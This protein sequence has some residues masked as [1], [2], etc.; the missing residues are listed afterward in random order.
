MVLAEILCTCGHRFS[1]ADDG[2]GSPHACPSCHVHNVLARKV[3]GASAVVEAAPALG[4]TAVRQTEVLGPVGLSASRVADYGLPGGTVLGPYRIVSRIGRGGM[5][6]VYEA[7]DDRLGSRVALKVLSPDLAV[8]ADFVKRF[9]REATAL[10][11]LSD[12]RIA[13]VYFSGAAEGLPFFAMEF[14][15]GR[16]LE[17][18]L[19]QEGAAQPPR[20]IEWMREAARGLHS[21]AMRGIIHRDVKPT[22]LLID[23]QGNLRIVDFGLAK[24]V[25]SESRLTMTGQVVGTPFYL[26][27]EQGLG[28]A[29]D[30]R[31]DIYSLGATFYHLLTG[32]PPFEAEGGAVSIIM[33]HI[34][35]APEPVSQRRAGVPGALARIVMR[36]LAKDPARRYQDY[37]SLIDDLDAAE[38]GKP[39]AAPAEEVSI[40]RSQPSFVVVDELDDGSRLLRRASL[41]RRSLA[42]VVDLGLLKLL[43]TG[44]HA[45]LP[46][47]FEPQFF[48]LPLSF[49]YLA[50]G[51][52]AGGST[53]GKRF[54][55]L[56]VARPDG[57]E[58]GPGRSIARAVLLAP[59]WTLVFWFRPEGVYTPDRLAES[60][61]VLISDLFGYAAPLSAI[62]LAIKAAVAL[63]L[64]DAICVLFTRKSL[65][66]HDL[67]SG[68]S[69]FR[70][71]PVP[72]RKR[73]RRK[74]RHRPVAPIVPVLF[75][76]VPGGGQLINGQMGKALLMFIGI[77]VGAAAFPL[78]GLAMYGL[79]ALEAY[80]YAV[81]RRAEWDDSRN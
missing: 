23:R 1:V 40:R 69:V 66:L 36:C 7:V 29:V 62:D 5:G 16:N 70:E 42:L 11:G 26:S 13:K 61:Q 45:F 4:E 34:N 37:E 30:Q 54:F 32:K 33:R 76:W 50:I 22:N 44:L 74:P 81:D 59:I 47:G 27:P 24:A 64:M 25:D 9:H 51:D 39:V 73:Q 17:E 6:S 15:D 52:A 68:T 10:A 60:L 28:K 63:V 48:F 75:A 38:Q 43:H 41:F 80:R 49:L 19:L 71:D 72:R 14:I 12:S 31:S 67:L 3:N 58:P 46:S 20:V 8:Q 35:D 18:I 79:S 21:A 55:R 53:V 65:A 77:V 2:T 56:R 57:I 78:I